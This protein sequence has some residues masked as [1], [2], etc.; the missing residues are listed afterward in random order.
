MH[1]AATNAGK[2]GYESCEPI[3]YLLIVNGADINIE[4][5]DYTTPLEYAKKGKL[6]KDFADNL[7]KVFDEQ[8]GPPTPVALSKDRVYWG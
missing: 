2:A 8:E 1:F 7:K 3:C 6:G 4:N 5:K